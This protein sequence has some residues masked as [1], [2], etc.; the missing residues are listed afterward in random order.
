MSRFEKLLP[1]DVSNPFSVASIIE[2]IQA[3]P[4]VESVKIDN[5]IV[6]VR[7]T[8]FIEEIDAMRLDETL[9]VLDHMHV[10]LDFEEAYEIHEAL[11]THLN[12]LRVRLNG[13]LQKMIMTSLHHVRRSE[14]PYA[15]SARD[16]FEKRD[17]IQVALAE[18]LAE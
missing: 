16:V 5:G 14:V 13:M 11:F 10:V 8:G 3:D 17:S 12:P 15:W 4:S 1:P 2:R 18:L 7:L 6:V 9:K